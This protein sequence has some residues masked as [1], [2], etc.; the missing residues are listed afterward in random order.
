M[1]ISILSQKSTQYTLQ[2][3]CC[4][5]IKANNVD[6]CWICTIVVRV[7]VV[8]YNYCFNNILYVNYSNLSMINIVLYMNKYQF[9]WCLL[10]AAAACT[11]SKR[12]SL[13]LGSWVRAARLRLPKQCERVQRRASWPRH[14]ALRHRQRFGLR[15]MTQRRLKPG[16]IWTCN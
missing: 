16:E 5:Y 4:G 8:Y 1:L 12:S 14:C 6:S 11:G 2:S 10:Q 15:R 13:C 7:K 9:L 3:V